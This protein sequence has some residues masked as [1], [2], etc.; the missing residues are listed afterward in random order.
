M[1]PK[2]KGTAMNASLENKVAIVTGGTSGIGKAAALALARAGTKVVVAGRRENEGKAVVQA[3]EKSGGKALFV[4]TDVT[5]EADVKALVDKTVATFGR[6]DIAFNN[7]GTEGQMGLTTD[8]QTPENYQT[9]FDI[10]VK[11]VLLSMKHEA[12]AMLRNGGGSIVNTSS[13]AGRIGLPGAGVYVA[14]KHAVDGLSKSAALEFAKKGIRVNTV[15]PGT[16]QTEMIGRM[17]GE[18]ESDAKQWW[19]SR[20]PVGRFGSPEEVAAAVVWLA[21]PEASFVTGTDIAVDG[22][23]LAQ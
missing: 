19:E 4:K 10:N 7:A 11:G 16:I 5:R 1:K 2:E 8:Q 15:S 23:Y 12:A 13:I 17:L 6:L 20:H 14:S 18:G 22:G 21:S 3:I 9:I